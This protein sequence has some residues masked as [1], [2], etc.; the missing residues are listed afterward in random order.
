MRIIVLYNWPTNVYVRKHGV[1]D[2]DL[3]TQWRHVNQRV[4]AVEDISD[5]YI[6]KFEPIML[7]VWILF[8]VIAW[9]HLDH[10]S[11]LPNLALICKLQG[12]E[13]GGA[14]IVELR[15][16]V[17]NAK[18][19]Y[20]LATL[21]VLRET[22]RTKRQYRI[23]RINGY[24]LQFHGKLHLDLKALSHLVKDGNSVTTL[25]R[26]WNVTSCSNM[27]ATQRLDC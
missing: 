22:W 6:F 23:C 11:R 16:K 9:H 17:H 26:C 13:V 21:T 18:I 12:C 10:C 24:V 14:A 8:K 2:V 19:G 4:H 1:C 7:R 20:M 15:R 27:I 3:S 25:F 5:L